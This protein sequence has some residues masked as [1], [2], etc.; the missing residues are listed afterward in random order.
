MNYIVLNHSILVYE[1]YSIAHSLIINQIE[2]ELI[3]LNPDYIFPLISDAC[4]TDENNYTITGCEEYRKSRG[5]LQNSPEEAGMNISISYSMLVYQRV[6]QFERLLRAV[7]RPSNYYCVH[8]DVDAPASIQHNFREIIKCFDNVFLP[9]RLISVEWGKF[10]V[11][12]ADLI[13]A[14][15]LLQKPGWQYYVNVNAYEF[16]LKTNLEIQK[17]AKILNVGNSIEKKEPQMFRLRGLTPPIP[18]KFWKG[19]F[20]L[21]ACRG[22]MDYLIN[23]KSAQLFIEWAR[24]IDVPDETVYA[25][26]NHNP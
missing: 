13:C 15:E 22:L 14:R 2:N 26:L 18:V 9:A 23:N 7:W 3:I 24:K 17:I 5:F 6:C 1:F 10:S 20:H 19:E 8:V 25:T 16:P 4:Y 12:E 21:F 11:V